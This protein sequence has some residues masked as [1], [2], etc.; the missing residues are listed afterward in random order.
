MLFLDT[1]RC[2]LK[3]STIEILTDNQALKP[4]FMNHKLSEREPRCL[5]TL[6]NIES[7]PV[8]EQSWRIH[9][10]GH[11]LSRAPHNS[12][13]GKKN[14]ISFNVLDVP[15]VDFERILGKYE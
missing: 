4:F 8:T 6:G 14:F 2:Y 1:F 10:L 13:T 12:E 3:G 15:E 9:V 11:A 7:F 5:E